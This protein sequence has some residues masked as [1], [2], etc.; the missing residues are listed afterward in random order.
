MVEMNKPVN[1]HAMNQDIRNDSK[2]RVKSEEGNNDS[3]L[4]PYQMA[5]LNKKPKEE[6]EQNKWLIGQYLVTKLN[7]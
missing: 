2:V 5:I 4:N 3:D 1:I 7:M 6:L